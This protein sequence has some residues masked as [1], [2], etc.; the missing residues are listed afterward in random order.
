MVCSGWWEAHSRLRG[1]QERLRL[2]SKSVATQEAARWLLHCGY[3][4]WKSTQGGN[5]DFWQAHNDIRAWSAKFYVAAREELGLE[6][7]PV[8]QD[9]PEGLPIPGDKRPL[10]N[11]N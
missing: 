1:L 3:Y 4:Q 6:N 2:T 8:Y 5:G 11:K 9:P 10:K 7:S